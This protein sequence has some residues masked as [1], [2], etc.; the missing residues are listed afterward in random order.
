MIYYEFEIWSSTTGLRLADITGLPQK[1]SF[2]LAR[3]EEETLEFEL[4]LKDWEAYCARRNADPNVLLA[5][6]VTEILMKRNGVY[7]K[8]FVVY[9][10]DFTADDSG[11][12]LNVKADGYLNRFRNRYVSK[13]YTQ[14]NAPAIANDLITTTQAKPRGDWGIT[15]GDTAVTVLRDRTYER[16]N[17]KEEIVNIG[18]L[19]TGRFD[20]EFK[21]AVANGTRAISFNTYTSIGSDRLNVPLSFPDNILSFKMPRT[22]IATFNEITALGSGFG[23]E[24]LSSVVF[25]ETSQLNLGLEEDIQTYND[26]IIQS[27]LNQHA[28]SA[29][30]KSKDIIQIPEI[31]VDSTKIDLSTLN[32]GDRRRIRL[33]TFKMLDTVDGIFKIEKIN[34]TLDDND[35][36]LITVIVDNYDV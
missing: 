8:G 21:L 27:T 16:K 6:L 2:S 3:N 23:D 13:T 24:Q 25:D 1:R 30:D 10:I 34:V 32:I 18:S 14:F 26:V 20:H 5:P 31:T 17:V 15:I 11:V 19:S 28:A 7:Y 35:A 9:H 12:K 33:N 36:E 22:G 29:L 4:D